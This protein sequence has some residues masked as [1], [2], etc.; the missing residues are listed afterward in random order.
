MDFSDKNFKDEKIRMD[1]NSFVQCRFENCVMEYGGGPP[2]TMVSCNISKCQWSFTDAASNTVT[3]MSA[4]YHGM[5][6]GGRELIEQT[7]ENIRRQDPKNLA[8]RIP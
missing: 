3:F 2:P 4:I 5:G 7:F 8:K 1:G 6:D